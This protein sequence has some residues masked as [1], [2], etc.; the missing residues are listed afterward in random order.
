MICFNDDMRRDV[1]RTDYTHSLS[2]ALVPGEQ[3]LSLMLRVI[4]LL[5][6]VHL[7]LR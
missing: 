2:P 3:R 5:A 6:S 7:T 4:T 1:L